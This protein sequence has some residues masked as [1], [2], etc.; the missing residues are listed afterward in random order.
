LGGEGGWEVKETFLRSVIFGYPGNIPMS[1][2]RHLN[3]NQTAFAFYKKYS[4]A[5]GP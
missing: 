5:L 3:P 4:N 2:A 1:N